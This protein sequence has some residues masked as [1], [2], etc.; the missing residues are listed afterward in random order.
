MKSIERIFEL[1]GNPVDQ[2]DEEIDKIP[3][4]HNPLILAVPMY[5]SIDIVRPD[6]V[7]PN[8]TTYKSFDRL[9]FSSFL[10]LGFIPEISNFFIIKNRLNSINELDINSIFENESNDILD[11]FHERGQILSFC[12]IEKRLNP[13]INESN[14]SKRKFYHLL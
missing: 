11:R 5:R 12:G 2:N 6:M 7:L 10:V 13:L 3:Y 8:F 4:G 1:Y 14:I 9:I